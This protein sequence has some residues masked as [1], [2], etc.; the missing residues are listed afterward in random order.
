MFHWSGRAWTSAHRRVL[1][2]YFSFF[3]ICNVTDV[4]VVAFLPTASSLYPCIHNWTIPSERTQFNT[5]FPNL[6]PPS[7]Y[8]T[9]SNG[10]FFPA[11][12]LRGCCVLPPLPCWDKLWILVHIL[13]PPL[14]SGRRASCS[15]FAMSSLC[16]DIQRAVSETVCSYPVYELP[17]EARFDRYP[18]DGRIQSAVYTL[19]FLSCSLRMCANWATG[20]KDHDALWYSSSQW[21]GVSKSF[22]RLRTD[23]YS[24]VLVPALTPFTRFTIGRCAVNAS[25]T[26]P[27]GFLDSIISHDLSTRLSDIELCHSDIFMD[28]QHQSTWFP[29]SPPC[30]SG[31]RS[32]VIIAL[33]DIGWKYQISMFR[34]CLSILDS[35]CLQLPVANTLNDLIVSIL[36]TSLNLFPA[37]PKWQHTSPSLTSVGYIR[38]KSTENVKGGDV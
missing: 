28:S 7:G 23:I 1:G 20:A 5:S 15:E 11:N 3:G 12:N 31:Y 29:V 2:K 10:V 37:K 21:V 6:W 18:M 16:S 8:S 33:V 35:H 17:T 25:W 34:F 30:A 38:T 26:F 19:A 27:T 24:I 32:D 36:S 4:N 13:Y 22:T 14:F 9:I